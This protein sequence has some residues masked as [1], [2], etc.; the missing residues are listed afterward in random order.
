MKLRDWYGAVPI[1]FRRV[2]PMPVSFEFSQAERVYIM[3]LMRAEVNLRT[4]E[5]VYGPDSPVTAYTRRSVE[6]LRAEKEM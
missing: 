4:C 2:G 5:A 3:E 1:G 6:R